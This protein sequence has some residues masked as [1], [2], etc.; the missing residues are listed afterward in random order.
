MFVKLHSNLIYSLQK[1]L[2][3]LKSIGKTSCQKSDIFL[4][5]F[6]YLFYLVYQFY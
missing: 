5:L 4:F 1:N 2:F 6:T 3:D